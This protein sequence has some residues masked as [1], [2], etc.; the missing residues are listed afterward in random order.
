MRILHTQV[1]TGDILKVK[2]R[3]SVARRCSVYCT[4]LL[5]LHR[6]CCNLFFTRYQL[7]DSIGIVVV[8]GVL[9]LVLVLVWSFFKRYPALDNNAYIRIPLTCVLWI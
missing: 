3:A 5:L 2:V 8:L 4:V 9:V 6:K 1:S 7:K